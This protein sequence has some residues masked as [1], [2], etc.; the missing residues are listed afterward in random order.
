MQRSPRSVG[1]TLIE[2]LVVIVLISILAATAASRFFSTDEIQ[3]Q[4]QRDALINLLRQV[5]MQ[6]MQDGAAINADGDYIRCATVLLQIS[7]AGIARQNACNASAS[8]TVDSSD[9]SQISLSGS[10][11]N[12]TDGSLPLFL[13]FDSWGKPRSSCSSGCSISFSAA[14]ATATLC[15]EASGY[16]GSC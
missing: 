11:V 6:S 13:R 5:Q 3:P 8:F 16:I 10:I 1:F 4:Q 2:L 15:I 9:L 12:S 7:A 14:G